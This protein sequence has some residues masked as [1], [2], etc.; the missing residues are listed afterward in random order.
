[1]VVVGDILNYVQDALG[2][3][4]TTTRCVQNGISEPTECGI[5]KFVC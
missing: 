5:K 2:T 3:L 1:M 4:D